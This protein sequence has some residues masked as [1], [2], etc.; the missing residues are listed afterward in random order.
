MATKEFIQ[1]RYNNAVAKI[2]KAQNLIVKKTALLAKKKAT[3]AK[4]EDERDKY[5]INCDIE[6]LEDDIKRKQRELERELIP[7]RDKWEAELA[8]V[9][10]IVRDIKPILDFLQL[11]KSRVVEYY[12]NQR[13]SEE[14]AHYKNSVNEA[15]KEYTELYDKRWKILS[16][17]TMTRQELDANLAKL[18][19]EYRSLQDDYNK[20]YSVVI[21]WEDQ[22]RYRG[23]TFEEV[24][25]R[26]LDI[27]CDAKYDDL[28]ARI[29]DQCGEILSC[30]NLYVSPMGNI[31]GWVE[32]S[33]GDVEVRTIPAGGYNIQKFHYRILV[34]ARDKETHK[35]VR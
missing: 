32:G 7:S 9:N 10:S 16:D 22:A 33:K 15:Y 26:A 8:K 27:E 14:R 11:W 34:Y 4:T 2:Q 21:N 35:V 29:S 28:V 31:D 5:W 30:S 20:E 1:E 13:T 24:M 23:L 17:G 12:T 19:R 3:L 18:K 25:N 6:N